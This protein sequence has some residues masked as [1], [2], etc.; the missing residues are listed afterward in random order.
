MNIKGFRHI[1][2]LC[3]FQIGDQIFGGCIFVL[4]TGVARIGL[5]FRTAGLHGSLGEHESEGV[6]VCICRFSDGRHLGHVAAD[7]AAEGVDAV[8]RAAQGRRM[9]ALAKS[10][11]KQPGFRPDNDQW[12]GHLADSL[13]SALT[14]VD[15]V[16]GDAAYS[17]FGMFTFLPIQVLLV[18]VF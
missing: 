7:T 13:Q 1:C 14:D 16:A 6:T 9:A 3:P 4:M 15:I 11:V 2:L 17:H 8:N 12:V 18:G 10:V 5:L